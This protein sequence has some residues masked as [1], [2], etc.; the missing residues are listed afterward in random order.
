MIQHNRE[1]IDEYISYW[2]R[3]ILENKDFI[4]SIPEIDPN[5]DVF[6]EFIQE[7]IH[8]S[9]F[10]YDNIIQDDQF[11]ADS[12]E[13]YREER[14]E[15]KITNKDELLRSYFDESNSIRALVYFLDQFQN[16]VSEFK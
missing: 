2:D 14:Q 12:V 13:K 6:N 9:Y 3:F 10:L 15:C 11:V 8:Q 7:A 16:V 4:D 1:V 5:S